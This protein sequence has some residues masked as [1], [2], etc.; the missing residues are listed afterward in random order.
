MSICLLNNSF[1]E[2]TKII[3][4]KTN[5][6]KRNDLISK[7]YKQVSPRRVHKKIKYPKINEWINKL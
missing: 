4:L 5:K 1:Q 2:N 3:Y 7:R 6:E